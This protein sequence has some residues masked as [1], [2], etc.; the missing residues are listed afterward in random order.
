M[1]RPFTLETEFQSPAK[2][3]QFDGGETV[4]QI[5]V[6]LTGANWHVE[7]TAAIPAKTGPSLQR[8]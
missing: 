4:L 5:K 7:N 6:K 2:L 1:A 3:V 8:R